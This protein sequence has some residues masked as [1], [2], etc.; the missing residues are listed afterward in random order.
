[1][2]HEG[3]TQAYSEDVKTLMSA[4]ELPHSS[5]LSS[6]HPHIAEKGILRVGGRIK[7]APIPYQ[8][9]YPAIIP[10]KNA[11]VPLIVNHLHRKLNHS[12]EDVLSELVLSELVK[13]RRSTVKRYAFTCLT[14]RVVHLEIA[15]LLDADSFIMALR[16]MI[17]T[18]SCKN[19]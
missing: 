6:R 10:K 16:K 17:A 19:T 11:I 4:K 5:D 9:K 7:H 8:A 15:H 13:Q 12:A 14:T 2:Y 18:T 3:P 1:M